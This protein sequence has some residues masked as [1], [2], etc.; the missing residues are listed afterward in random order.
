MKLFVWN[1]PISV[2]YGSTCLYVVAETEEQARKIAEGAR[3]SKYGYSYEDG[4]V[5]FDKPLGAP[6]RVIDGPCAEVYF[7]QE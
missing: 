4:G 7:W 5:Q 3:M 2:K 1:K 6:S